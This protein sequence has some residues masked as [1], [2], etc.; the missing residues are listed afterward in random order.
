MLDAGHDRDVRANEA[1]VFDL[2]RVG[3]VRQRCL[4][5][6]LH[7]LMEGVP[8]E[9]STSHEVDDARVGRMERDELVG[10]VLMLLGIRDDLTYGGG[11]CFLIFAA[12]YDRLLI[13]SPVDTRRTPE[14]FAP[15]ELDTKAER[16]A[17]QV[18]M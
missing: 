14:R 5:R 6:S 11:L 12:H 17:P 2:Y 1:N 16:F 10:I 3:H 15:I 18:A 7:G 4:Q 8:A 9:Y 13:T